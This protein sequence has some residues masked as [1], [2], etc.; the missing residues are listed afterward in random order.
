MRLALLRA[1]HLPRILQGC[2]DHGHQVERILGAFRIEQLQRRQQKRRQRL[3]E[4]EVLR[5]VHG[6]RV[7]VLAVFVHLVHHHVGIDERLQH[8]GGTHV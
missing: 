1:Q 8:L 3:I 6:D 2:L 5:Q 4:R 7:H